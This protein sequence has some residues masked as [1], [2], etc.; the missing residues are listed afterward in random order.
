MILRVGITES[1]DCIDAFLEL[2]GCNLFAV[3]TDT[4]PPHPGFSKIPTPLSP[5]QECPPLYLPPSLTGNV[6]HPLSHRS[7]PTPILCYI[8]LSPTLYLFYLCP[9]LVDR[10]RSSLFALPNDFQRA[11]SIIIAENR[12]NLHPDSNRSVRFSLH[13]F[14]GAYNRNER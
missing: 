7:P 14:L 12:S 13:C 11:I 10:L 2:S 3:V 8:C 5:L 9:C 6:S 1:D 4:S